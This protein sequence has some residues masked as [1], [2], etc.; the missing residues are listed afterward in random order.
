MTRLRIKLRSL[1]MGPGLNASVDV[2]V[3][4]DGTFEIRIGDEEFKSKSY[5]EVVAKANAHLHD[6]D[7]IVW[8]PVISVRPEGVTDPAL[9]ARLLVEGRTP[10]NIPTSVG[11]VLSRFYVGVVQDRAN[12]PR[13]HLHWEEYDLLPSMGDKVVASQRYTGPMPDV[14]R[15]WREGSFM[16]ND[17]HVVLHYTEESWEKLVLLASQ[18]REVRLRVSA[19][20]AQDG[21]HVTALEG[22]LA[23]PALTVK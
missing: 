1:Y 5:D 2:W 23:G 21:A 10:E 11:I 19:L 8:M 4:V 22:R 14:A 15:P 18:I 13:L 3:T 20:F 16:V 6:Q 7:S 12:A 9:A 17:P